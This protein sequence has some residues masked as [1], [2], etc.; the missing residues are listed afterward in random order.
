MRVCPT[1]LVRAII[2]TFMHGYQNYLAQLLSSRSRSAIRTICSGR[3]KVKVTLEGQKINW[4]KTKLARAMICTFLH[5]LQ[6]YLPQLLT[7]RSKSAI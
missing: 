3:L 7:W 1:G 2:C 6:N 5:R 4:S